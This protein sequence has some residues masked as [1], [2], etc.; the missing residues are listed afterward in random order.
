M[1][2]I[3]IGFDI[4]PIPT[5]KTLVPLY[6]IVQGVP[7]RDANGNILVT[8]EEGPVEALSK[9]ENSLS[10][11]VNNEAPK[12]VLK[13]AEVFAETS[14]VST[15]LLGIPRAETQLSLFSDV[16]T[17]GR[18]PEEWE[19]YNYNGVNG[20]PNGWYTR[21]NEIYGNHFYTR[22]VENINEQ[23]LTIESFPV[24]FTFPE[25][26]NYPGYSVAQWERYFNFINLGNELY[27]QY[28]GSY[29]DF[30]N[31]N[32]LSSEIVSTLDG[33]VEYPVDEQA[34][35]DAIEKWCQA[36]MNMRDS[37]LLDPQTNKPLRFPIGYDATN[38]RPGAGSSN[39][40]FG[41]LQS[42]KAYRYQ[43][44]RIS[45]FTYGF[46]CSRDEASL[47]NI[48]EWGIGNPTDEYVFQ[49]RGPQFN[50][51]RRSTVR[52][53]VDVLVRMG[54]QE[55]DQIVVPSRE[56]FVEDQF[57]ELVIQREFFNGDA[58]NGNG[59]S[60]YL[61]DPTKVTM[62][63]IEFG[64]YGAIGAKFFAYVPV[65]NGDARWVLMHTLTIEN[66]LGEPCL[67]DPYFKFRYLQDIRDTS[68]IRSPQYLYKYGASCYIDGGDNSAGK[69]YTYTADEKTVDTTRPNS[70]I[71]IYPKQFISN[72]DGYEKL[73]KKNVYPVDLKVECDQLT[74]LEVVEI[75]GC[76]AFG[77]HYSPS[78][79]AKTIGKIRS[80]NID[81]AGKNF[82]INPQAPISITSISKAAIAILTTSSAHGY[83]SKQTVTIE[84]ETGMIEVA[85]QTYYVYVI[86]STQVALYL[87]PSLTLPLDSSLFTDFAGDG[88]AIGFPLLRDIDNDAKLINLGIWS[89]YVDRQGEDG[90]NFQRIGVEGLYIKSPG[91]DLP[92]EVWL[93]GPLPTEFSTVDTSAV[94]FTTYYDS[95]AASTYPITGNAV[96][97]NFLNPVTSES[98]GQ[99]CEF[100]IGITEKK[101]VLVSE[102]N[103]VGTPVDVLKFQNKDGITNVDPN[104]DDVLYAEFT[105]SS[106]YRNRDGYE[107]GEGDAPAG[108]RMD[109]DYRLPRPAGVD[110]GICSG[111]K[112]TIEDRLA[113]TVT[114]TA[115]NPI[116]TVEDGHY[117]IW[118]E[119]P[120]SLLGD[121]N[122]IGGEF[123]IEDQ[124]S[125]L[126]FI[127]NIEQYLANAQ[128][129]A[130]GYFAPISGNPNSGAF[131]I[132]LSPIKIEDKLI[133]GNS[134]KSILKTKIFSFQPKPLYVTIWLRDRAR[135][136]N[137]TITEFINGTTRAFSPEWLTNGGVDIVS[138]GTSVMNV[139]AANFLSGERLAS[140]SVDI[141]N[142]Q[143]LRPGQLKDTLYIAP[144][145][146][147]KF[148]LESVYGPDRTT[149][150]PG[151]LNVSA[152]FVTAKSLENN[153][154]NI[155][156]VSLTTKEA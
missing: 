28:V 83:F 45:G 63:K 25:G 73:N 93:G 43:P 23:A 153:D 138:S 34:G 42:K 18:N 61:L 41:L 54:F 120:S 146:S 129:Q 147:N 56:P 96:D 44:G 99:V 107:S 125:G 19:Y 71:G 66:Q 108:I 137:V 134:V 58:L 100:L 69:F 59:R 142:V 101:P 155:V 46:R 126:T 112:V 16:S 78:L 67:Q 68:N 51:V 151:V 36:W 32:F 105:Y 114:Y 135:V 87:D 8:E 40:F 115:T 6:D 26:P 5:V 33:D 47:D 103:P 3:K 156:S 11:V 95:I 81:S 80:I 131:T 62:Y 13:I 128:T 65:D 29:P 104:L 123:G 15:N 75:D 127:G 27:Q 17:Y 88:V 91:E 141:Q 52:L 143:P 90:G 144:N 9:A 38:T 113:F 55:E 94:R 85:D 31:K 14:E 82:T 149:I 20:R 70:I 77:H 72:K 136:N 2:Q 79:H 121:F 89:T 60:G 21:L 92:Q 111:M 49:V 37:L 24:A 140:T 53:P 116:T 1:P 124:P 57:Y 35:Y 130:I 10:I 152:T 106:I 132:K 7:L 84:G 118:D 4:I 145:K 102:Q 119:E 22:L 30:A 86:N 74:Q 150:A 154:V 98:T 133:T 110:S 139:P 122:L 148:S 76:P 109:I 50:I 39:R 64:W 48:I 97:V 117:I 12:S